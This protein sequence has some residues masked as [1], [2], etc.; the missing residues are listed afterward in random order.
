MTDGQASPAGAGQAPVIAVASGKGGVGKSTVAVNLALALTAQGGP[1]SAWS[2][3]TCTA[4]ISRAC[5]AVPAQ[6]AAYEVLAGRVRQRIAG[7]G[8]A[9][10]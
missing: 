6:V 4:P 1:M 2:T 5:G 8:A 9:Q 7:T 3:P 10:A